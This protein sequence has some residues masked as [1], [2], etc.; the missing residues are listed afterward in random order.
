LFAN[1]VQ[2]FFAGDILQPQVGIFG[3]GIASRG[4]SS[5]ET[6]VS[7]STEAAVISSERQTVAVSYTVQFG[8]GK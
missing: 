3:G 2:G 4:G 8:A 1:P 7:A 5:L 6:A